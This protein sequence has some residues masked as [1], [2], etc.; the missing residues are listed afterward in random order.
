MIRAV[1]HIALIALALNGCAPA[2]YIPIGSVQNVPSL[3]DSSKTSISLNLGSGGISPSFAK[4]LGNQN[5]FITNLSFIKIHTDEECETCSFTHRFLLEMA[6]GRFSSGREDRVLEWF[7]GLG[8]GKSDLRENKFKW[9]ASDGSSG[10]HEKAKFIQPFGQ[11]DYGLIK[12]NSEIVYSIKVV[13]PYFISYTHINNPDQGA[14]ETINNYDDSWTIFLQPAVTTRWGFE[15]FKGQFQ[16]GFSVPVLA[17]EY[18][19]LSLFASIGLTFK[20]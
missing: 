1:L 18:S 20:K 14:D 15:H 5:M 4:V 7:A 3:N 8:A 10:V 2:A 19:K 17:W 16:F 9:G 12:N 11:F 6:W 13:A